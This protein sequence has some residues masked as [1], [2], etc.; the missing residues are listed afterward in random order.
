MS[1]PIPTDELPPIPPKRYF[2]IG[3][4][5]DL[6]DVKTHVLA[7]LGGRSSTTYNRSNDA[8]T[9]AYYQER[10]ILLVRRIRALLYD[11]GYTIGGARQ[12]L[13]GGDAK[14]DQKPRPDSWSARP[15]PS[16]RGCSP[17]SSRRDAALRGGTTCRVPCRSGRHRRKPEWATA[18]VVPTTPGGRCQT[19]DGPGD[20]APT[21]EH[22][23]IAAN[24]IPR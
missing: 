8:A 17:F 11:Q 12:K 6:C 14:Q 18:R 9:G 3:E 15:S 13:S 16:W 4:V 5:S 24:R 10:E 23:G 7:L 20:L 19:C 22:C 1:D 21:G 2:T